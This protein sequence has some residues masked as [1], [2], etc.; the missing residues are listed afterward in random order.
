MG[1][2]RGFGR[3]CFGGFGNWFG[4]SEWI[5]VVLIIIVILLILDD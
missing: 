2:C 5:W 4:G 3:G 1:C